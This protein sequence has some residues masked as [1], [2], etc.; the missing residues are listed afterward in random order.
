[1]IPAASHPRSTAEHSPASG[2]MLAAAAFA[3]LTSSDVIFKWMAQG[4]PVYQILFVNACF[5]IWPVVVWA[6]I[7][8]GF[9]RLSTSRPLQHFIRG[10][11]SML[12]S[13]A[14]IY[15]YSNLSL[16]SFYTFVFTGP[17]VVTALSSFW[18]GEKIERARWAAILIGFAG[19]LFVVDP[20]SSDP[21]MHGSQIIAGRLAAMLSV[22]CYSLSVIMIRR[23]RLGESNLT[24]SFYGYISAILICG[25]LYLLR[26]GPELKAGDIAHLVLSGCLSS[27]SSICM[28]T[29]YH[30]S[31]VA[32]VAPFQYTQILW[33][34]LAGYLL[35]ASIPS[36]HLIAGAII[37]AA[38]GLFVIYYEMR[39]RSA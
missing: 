25:G 29:A 39:P 38:S 19:V 24:F 10:T 21:H 26:G 22:F 34:A 15:A 28:M 35:W 30:R 33:G 11:V 4:H 36:A 12:S 16:T 17:L 20:L 9:T 27:G 7:S 5:A 37:V 6:L 1:M 32:L 3:L 18:L 31:P 14:A 13:F 23:M 8:G 2:M